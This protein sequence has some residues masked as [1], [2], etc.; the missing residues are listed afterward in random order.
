MMSLVTHDLFQWVNRGTKIRKNLMPLKTYFQVSKFHVSL[1][2]FIFR[3]SQKLSILKGIPKTHFMACMDLLQTLNSSHLWKSSLIWGISFDGIYTYM[4]FY[5]D[6]T[7][8]L[9]L[10]SSLEAE[11]EYT[12]GY[13]PLR[14]RLSPRISLDCT[15]IY[16]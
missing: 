3:S 13:P 15:F 2:I 1:G 5:T 14:I 11:Y 12:L 9:T 4:K 7:W 16:L 8:Q 10:L 6:V